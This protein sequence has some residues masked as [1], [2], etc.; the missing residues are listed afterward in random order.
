M[1][2]QITQKIY[3]RRIKHKNKRR[4]FIDD[5]SI[6]ENETIIEI[7]HFENDIEIHVYMN[8]PILY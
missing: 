4:K 3:F 8:N 2:L 5:I 7:F 1:K 6:S